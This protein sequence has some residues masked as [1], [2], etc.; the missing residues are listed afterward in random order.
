M[1]ADASLTWDQVLG[2]RLAQQGLDEASS[3][4]SDPVALIGHLAGVQTQVESSALQVLAVRGAGR[5]DLDALL[6]RDRALLKTWAM[7]GT[8]HLLPAAEWRTWIAVMRTRE[9]RITPGWE[10]YHGITKAELEA[11]TDAIPEALAGEPLTRDEL[12]DRIA[13]LTKHDHL[14]EVLRSGWAQVFKPAANQG[15]LCQ[16]PPRGKATTFTSPERWLAGGPAGDAPDPDP[17]AAAATVLARFLDT[18]GPATREDLARWLGESP[19]QARL[20][21]AAHAD[22]LVEVDVEGNKGWMTPAGA[23]AAS[24]AGA[25]EGVALLPGF[26]PWVL[27]PISH[28]AHTIPP[29]RIDDVSRTAGWISPVLLVDGRVA[30][31][32]ESSVAG[33]VTTV[34]VTPFGKLPKRVVA[35]VRRVLAAGALAADGTESDLRIQP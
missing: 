18:N 24:R 22:E 19:K 13:A 27:A 2:W 14:G 32:W 6:W 23:A 17:H 11:V 7:R 9:W 35:E 29:G 12:A 15:L 33:D 26:D 25:P 16:G 28:R 1:A 30:G 10:K 4:P 21:L 8:L 5:V 34:T 31:T 20:L 3:V